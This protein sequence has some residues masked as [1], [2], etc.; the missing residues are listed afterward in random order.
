[1][2][3]FSVQV[4][5]CE[6]SSQYRVIEVAGFVDSSTATRLEAAIRTQ[7]DAGCYDLILDLS[8]VDYVSSAGWGIFISVVRPVR[9]RGG[10]LK[11]I[12]MQE[13]VREVFELLEFQTILELHASA[14]KAIGAGI[15][16]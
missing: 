10:D 9:E 5:E 16:E 7:M 14:E 11:L 2:D 15:Q 12:G 6:E 8:K 4:R 13:D 1:M 3:G